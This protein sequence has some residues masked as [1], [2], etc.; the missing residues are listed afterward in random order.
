MNVP[1]DVADRAVALVVQHFEAFNQRDSVRA[2]SH[3]FHPP[4]M[5]REPLER[6]V[7]GMADLVPIRLVSAR[8]E[9][10]TGPRERSHGKF[11][12]IWITFTAEVHGLGEKTETIPV[13]WYIDT[14][15]FLIATRL[16]DWV[17]E[18]TKKNRETS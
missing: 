12:T 18:A 14:G 10:L 1:T 16:T 3:L 13:W 2:T 6:Y 5:S 9:R 8:F 7:R 4:G 17:F 11:A 15:Q